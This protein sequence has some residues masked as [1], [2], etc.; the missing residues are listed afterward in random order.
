MGLSRGVRRTSRSRNIEAFRAC[1]DREAALRSAGPT[2]TSLRFRRL[3]SA[4]M[5]APIVEVPASV[6]EPE[7]D[8]TTGPLGGRETKRPERRGPRTWSD[9]LMP[10]FSEFLG[11][12]M[13]HFPC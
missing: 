2:G 1:H 9:Q 4:P 7:A 8:G 5:T 11:I 10:D 12:F 6:Q 13:D 3:A